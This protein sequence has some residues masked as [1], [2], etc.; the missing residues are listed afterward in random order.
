MTASSVLSYIHD[1]LER[2]IYRDADGSGFRGID[3]PHRYTSPSIKGEGKFSFF[4]YWDTHFTQF[5]LYRTGHADVA[6]E[7]IQNMLWLIDRHGFMPNHVGLDNRSQSPYLCRMVRD[8]FAQIGGIEKDP[9]FFRECAEGIRS[10]YHFW[11]TARH[12]LTGLCRYAHHETKYG[13]RKFY[14][15][16]LV[17]RL[18]LPADAPDAEK[19]RIG[20]HY[21]ANAEATCDFSPR[22]TDG[23]CLDFCE[24]DLN[25]LLYEYEEA[26]AAWAPRLGWDAAF[27]A[28]AAQRR[29]ERMQALLWS[30]EKGLFLD[31]DLVNG[32]HSD[33]PALTGFQTL[34]TGVATH[35]QADRMVAQLPLFERD[36]GIAY[37]PDL[38]GC[39][40]FQW[41]FPNVWPPMVSILMT[42]LQRYGFDADA[43]R[44]A[45][46]Y[47]ATA[48]RLFARTGRLWEKTDAETGEVAGGEYEAAAMIGWSA[49]VYLQALELA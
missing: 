45:R 11:R 38:P 14:D 2:S 43:R 27:F 18:G 3:L 19:A 41:A 31:Y 13:C 28:E 22:F 30:E 9:G 44:L 7:N 46:K 26:L 10:E 16:A 33:V 49:G 6:K 24:P 5:A 37:T 20:G 32:R 21:L 36:H 29:R 23:R 35:E 15:G 8:Y 48:D 17:R 1:N 39:R 47:V 34:D 12:T 40:N 4:F 25:A 42:G